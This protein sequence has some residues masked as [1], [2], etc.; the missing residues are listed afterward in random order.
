MASF[1]PSFIIQQGGNAIWA[2]LRRQ[3][4]LPRIKTC[5]VPPGSIWL[6]FGFDHESSGLRP[7]LVQ[8]VQSGLVASTFKCGSHNDIIITHSHAQI[9]V[10]MYISIKTLPV[11]SPSSLNSKTNS[12]ILLS[13][14]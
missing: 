6:N 4:T 14:L 10:C 11:P 5:Y 2:L 8:L 3:L 1:A 13:L 9:T 12:L 7:D